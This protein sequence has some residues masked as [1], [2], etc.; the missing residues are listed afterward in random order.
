MVW[1]NSGVILGDA[2]LIGPLS[3][4][5]LLYLSELSASRT[6]EPTTL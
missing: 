1:L 5:K 6:R 4:A 2:K 3:L